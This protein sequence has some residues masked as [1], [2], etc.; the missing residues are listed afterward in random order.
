MRR[1]VTK[2]DEIQRNVTLQTINPSKLI[3]VKL[4]Q[5]NLSIILDQSASNNPQATIRKQ[6]SASNNPQATIRKQQS[7]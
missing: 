4:S 2:C 7:T 3:E 5:A 6:Q 1:N